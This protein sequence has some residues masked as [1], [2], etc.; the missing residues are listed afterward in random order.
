MKILVVGHGKSAIGR[1]S[2]Q[3]M[4]KAPGLQVVKAPREEKPML[5]RQFLNSPLLA[6]LV[7]R[8]ARRAH[9]QAS[10]PMPGGTGSTFKQNRRRE[11]KAAARRKQRRRHADARR[12]QRTC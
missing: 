5:L 3:V 12:R 9:R 7:A 11:L 10:R 2:D 1:L 8:D 6:K 4:A